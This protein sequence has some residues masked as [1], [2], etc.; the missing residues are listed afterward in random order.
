LD[1]TV[2]GVFKRQKSGQNQ[3]SVS[4]DWHSLTTHVFQQ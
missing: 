3:N 1:A 2:M 4:L